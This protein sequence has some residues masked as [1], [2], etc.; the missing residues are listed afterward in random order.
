MVEH[1]S[2]EFIHSLSHPVS[3]LAAGTVRN[4]CNRQLDHSNDEI[5]FKMPN[6]FFVSA[7]L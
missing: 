6:E 7:P 5:D 3:Q 2:V 4:T 1:I